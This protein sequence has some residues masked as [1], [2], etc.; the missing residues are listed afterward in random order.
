MNNTT[1]MDGFL[2]NLKSTIDAANGLYTG[3]ECSIVDSGYAL[4]VSSYDGDMAIVIPFGLTILCNA[5]TSTVDAMK[6]AF[7][8]AMVDGMVLTPA[9]APIF[10]SKD[11]RAG[12]NATDKKLIDNGIFEPLREYF[13]ISIMN[14]DAMLLKDP[15][16]AF[17]KITN[18]FKISVLADGNDATDATADA[19]R[20][21]LLKDAG[22]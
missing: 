2:N 15:S 18:E 13:G 7:S 22:L 9:Q 8:T 11:I 1:F 6:F 19:V 4:T 16:D 10:F 12:M 5:D 17:N 14:K 21:Q 20:A 3:V